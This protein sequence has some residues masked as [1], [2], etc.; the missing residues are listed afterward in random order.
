MSPSPSPTLAFSRRRTLGDKLQELGERSPQD[1][2][3]IEQ[4]VNFVL[5]ELNRKDAS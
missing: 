2:K 5:A 4:I 3:D 1:L